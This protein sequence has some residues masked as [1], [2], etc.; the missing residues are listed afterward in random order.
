MASC[1]ESSEE[2]AGHNVVFVLVDDLGYN[3]LGYMGSQYYETPHIDQLAKSGIVFTQAYANSRVCSPSRVSIMTGQ[4]SARTGV[5]DWI[6]AKSGEKWRE[7][8]RIDKLLPADYVHQLDADLTVLPEAMKQA[9]YKTFFAGKWHMGDE[10]SYP[11][12]HGFDIN[13]G[14]FEKG[15]PMGGYFS[16]Y[17]NPK[18][19]NG[20]KGE[21]LTMRLARETADFIRENK[22]TS[23]FAYLSFYA[24]HGPIQTT[25]EKWA[26]YR[27]KAVKM[28]VA[29]DGYTMERVLPY[30]SHQDNPVYA[31]L[32]ESMDDAV[33][34][35][36]GELK[37]S[38]LMDNTIVVFTSDNGGVVSGDSYS[39]NLKP[40][41]GGKGYQWEGGIRVPL[42]IYVPDAVV[43]NKVIDTPVVGSDLY[44]TILDLVNAELKPDVH[45]DGKSLKSLIYDGHWDERPLIWH[46]PHYGNQGGEPSSII[47]K[48]DWKLI[49]YYEDGRNELYSMANDLFENNDV[50]AENPVLVEELY[51]ELQSYLA[52]VKARYPVPDPLFD[53]EER[54]LRNVNI[55]EVLQQRLEDLRVQRLSE[56]YSPNA[57]WWGSAEVEE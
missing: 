41:R 34:L 11:E 26:K 17:K 22:D 53:I 50:S 35:V 25:Q 27:D 42:I 21:N 5:T 44:P 19:E 51:D 46:Y 33:G 37:A 23:F 12:D 10:G 48:G 45:R 14:G 30:R 31:G 54:R 55:E 57:D 32:V 18:L 4:F 20:P 28:G 47:R 40:L 43:Q 24:V 2:K 3:D 7:H 49:H 8:K 1:S 9:G 16:P 38:G 52:S 36:M 39:T 56:D 6:G 13:K 15:S 29:E